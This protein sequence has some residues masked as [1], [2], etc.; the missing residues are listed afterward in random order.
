[1][2]HSLIEIVAK[3]G[4]LLLGI[5]PKPDGTLPPEAEERMVAIG[6]WLKVNGTAIYNTRI[7]KNYQ[8]GN[9]FFTQS[10]QPGTLY[11]LVCVKEGDALP[12]TVEWKGN[13]PKKGTKIKLLQTG[14]TVKWVLEGD[15]VKVSLPAAMLK[16]KESYPAL[17]F[18]F[19]PAGE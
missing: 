19:T 17:A 6:Q 9:I 2:I 8:Q 13:L 3:G 12:A 1:V 7:T 10:K 18:A 15:S 14:Q 11:A 4:S 16:T 5:G